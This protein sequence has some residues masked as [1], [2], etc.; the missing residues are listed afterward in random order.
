MV[1]EDREGT[2]T[3]R[4]R[5]LWVL[6]SLAIALVLI[7]ATQALAAQG[8]ARVGSTST[9][10]TTETT[11]A[12]TEAGATDSQPAFDKN[13]F[14]HPLD[15]TNKHMPLKPGTTFVYAG[16]IGGGPAHKS[17]KHAH[18]GRKHAHKGRTN[19]RDTFVVTDQTKKILGVE[20]RVIHDTVW[21]AGKVVESTDDWFAQDDEGNLWYFGEFSTDIKNGKVK[22]HKGSWEGGVN[23]AEPGIIMEAHP[24]VGDTY[25]Q[26]SAPGVAEDRATVLSLAESLC[27]PYG[28]F[29]NVLETEEFS[30]LEP[31]VV[32]HKYYAPNVGQIKEV[33]V[34]GGSEESHLVSIR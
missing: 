7:G 3:I 28:C 22:G 14:H 31:S 2:K 16:K 26:E 18:K 11:K 33:V 25:Q 24:K 9:P 32:E 12:T 6:A 8:P 20:T 23:G 34:K 21:E 29:S 17:R 19:T 15:I 10:G 4:L 30:P 1:A 27:V 5:T 13:N